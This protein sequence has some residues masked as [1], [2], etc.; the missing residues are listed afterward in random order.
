MKKRKRKILVR[1]HKIKVAK[2]PD[3]KELLEPFSTSVQ[4]IDILEPFVIPF[5]AVTSFMSF[6]FIV[7]YYKLTDFDNAVDKQF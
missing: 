5:F 2:V 1:S 4:N 6:F 3:S 7:I